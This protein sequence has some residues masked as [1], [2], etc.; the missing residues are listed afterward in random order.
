M[1]LTYLREEV[2]VSLILGIQQANAYAAPIASHHLPQV[3]ERLHRPQALKLNISIKNETLFG[4]NLL[5]FYI[6]T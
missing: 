1:H 6:I 3:R 2:K 4:G 5:H